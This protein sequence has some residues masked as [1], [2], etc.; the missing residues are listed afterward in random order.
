[1]QNI[2]RSKMSRTLVIGDIHGGFKALQ[3]VLERAGVMK[4]DQLIF[5]GDYVDGWS[6]SSQ[7][8]QFLLE[9][10]EIQECIFIKGNHDAWCEDWLNLGQKPDLWLFNGG[11]STV[12]SYAD[13]SLEDLDIHLEFFQRMKNYHIDDQNRL[14][15]HA[16]YASMHGP[17][18][19]VYSSN[20]RWDRTLWETAVA[21]DKKLSKNSELYPKRLL[22]Y[23][24][25]FIGHTPT[26][27][28]GIKIPANK[29]NIWNMDTGAAYTGS[30]SIM[31]IDSK[32]FWQ[33]DPLP[34]LYPKEKGRN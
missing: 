29:A 25:I 23:K 15:I 18:K 5:L 24:E 16:G 30:L 34:S 12:E 19:E 11:K 28:I 9:L 4:N 22:L 27:D 32:Q 10:S 21:M 26:L 13:Y 33:S 17:E 31:D 14:F 8:V 2:F 3:Q 1:M 7:V 20:Y 6:E